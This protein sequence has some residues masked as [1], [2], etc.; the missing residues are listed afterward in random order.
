MPT[1]FHAGTYSAVRHYLRA[2]EA[3]GTDDA[4]TVAGK[5]RELPVED[6]FAHGGIVR[7]DGRMVHDMVFAQVKAPAESLGEWD[8][9]KVVRTVPG[10]TAFRPQSEGGCPLIAK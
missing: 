1:S 6:M 10:D 2:V 3:A 4:A 7:Q 8:L 5:M 9:Y